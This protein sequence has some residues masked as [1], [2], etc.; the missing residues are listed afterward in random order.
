MFEIFLGQ[1]FLIYDVLIEIFINFVRLDLVERITRFYIIWFLVGIF[2]FIYFFEK[3][4]RSFFIVL[5]EYV[6]YILIFLS[7]K[8]SFSA[9]LLFIFLN[10]YLY[11]LFSKN[12]LFLLNISWL[13]LF[14]QALVI[15]FVIEFF[16]YWVHV[17]LH[18]YYFLYK[19]SHIVHHNIK[20]LRW[21]NGIHDH[22]FVV[23]LSVLT[24]TLVG[25]LFKI[26]PP[27][28]IFLI[29][30]IDV[31]SSFSHLGSEYKFKLQ[32]TFLKYFILFPETHAKHHVDEGTWFGVHTPLYDYLF[33]IKLDLSKK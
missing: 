9:L 28:L 25:V 29:I 1:V 11:I 10:D 7:L 30:M 20:I 22:F 12:Y 23:F 4:I 18:K 19:N 3:N 15:F 16:N 13:P 24:T 2:F 17:L 8:V 5:K 21:S 6:V 31:T 26:S 32:N 27:V 14:V 33:K